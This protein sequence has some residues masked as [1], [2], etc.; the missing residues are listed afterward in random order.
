[1]ED[2]RWLDPKRSTRRVGP[3]PPFLSL[4]SFRDF[5]LQFEWRIS[6][7]GNSGVKYRI[8]RIWPFR[9]EDLQTGKPD[10]MP[11]TIEALESGTAI[12]FEYQLT[13]DENAPDALD[14]PSRSSAS[15]YR[16]VAPRKPGPVKAGSVH[17]SRIKIVRS[18]FEH[19]LD[20]RRVAAGSLDSGA[21]RAL[22]R[23]TE[24]LVRR[25]SKRRPMSSRSTTACSS[26]S[27]RM[28]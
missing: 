7:A 4:E 22:L 19:W 15:L 25:S 27:L 5:E 1:M 17:A 24:P 11:V 21:V 10:L 9:P 13:D 12:G 28:P 8:Q 3:G 14:S 6:R 20:G 18:R 2:R 16:L 26:T 23:R